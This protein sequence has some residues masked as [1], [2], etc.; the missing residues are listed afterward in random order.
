M[1]KFCL[2]IMLLFLLNSEIFARTTK[3]NEIKESIWLGAVGSVKY[4]GL[5]EKN[6]QVWVGAW[7]EVTL[8][9]VLKIEKKINRSDNEVVLMTIVDDGA[10]KS[11]DLIWL[12]IIRDNGFIKVKSWGDSINLSCFTLGG[13]EDLRESIIVSSK[14]TEY[15]LSC[16]NYS[17]LLKRASP[18]LSPK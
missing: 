16:V 12:K 4:R 18:S 6:G 13:L 11:G 8:R 15:P 14:D 7:Y 9:D 5:V 10:L 1:Y 17:E 2:T 3:S